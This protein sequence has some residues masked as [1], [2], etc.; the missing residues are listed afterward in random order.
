WTRELERDEAV[1]RLREH[2][3][4]AYPVN[5]MADLYSDPQLAH[6]QTWRP[7]DHPVQGRIHAAAPP[8]TLRGTPPVP[9]SPAPLLGGDNS[10]VL[11]QILGLKDSEIEELASQ[12]VLD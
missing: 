5:S 8:F 9:A 4:R 7:L 6:R 11:G 2:R 10:Y 12:G 1:S 3:L